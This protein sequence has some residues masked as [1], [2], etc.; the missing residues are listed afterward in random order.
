MKNIQETILNFFQNNPNSA[1][2]FSDIMQ[3][4]G[5]DYYNVWMELQRLV[6]KGFVVAALPGLNG[7]RKRTY[8]LKD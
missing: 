8:F 2:E 3:R 4:I 6:R 5:G 1:Y 7:G